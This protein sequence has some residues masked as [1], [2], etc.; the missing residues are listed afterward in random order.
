MF[1]DVA[2][3]LALVAVR[4]LQH[5]TAIGFETGPLLRMPCLG[6]HPTCRDRREPQRGPRDLSPRKDAV[7]V[8]E[9]GIELRIRDIDRLRLAN[10]RIAHTIDRKAPESFS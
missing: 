2:E 10:L 5:V 3:E 6:S 9:H 1:Q 4:A 7:A 8:A